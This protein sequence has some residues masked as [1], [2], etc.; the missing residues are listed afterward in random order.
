MLCSLTAIFRSEAGSRELLAASSIL[1]PDGDDAN[2]VPHI[3][4]EYDCRVTI[5]PRNRTCKY[6]C[7]EHLWSVVD[8]D[9]D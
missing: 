7:A 3:S 2:E 4:Q 9:F 6:N 1:F 5:P 8:I